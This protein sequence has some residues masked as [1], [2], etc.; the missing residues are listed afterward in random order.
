M[1]IETHDKGAAIRTQHC[2]LFIVTALLA[3]CGGGGG[4]GPSGPSTPQET[5]SSV[6]VTP[7]AASL[8][9]GETLQLT[10]TAVASNGSQ[11]TGCSFTF[12]SLLPVVAS[13]T[14]S[15]L[16]SAGSPGGAIIRVAANC[17]PAGTGT[18]TATITVTLALVTVGGIYDI[19]HTITGTN[20]LAVN[21]LFSTPATVSHTP[22]SSQIT[23]TFGSFQLRGT[24]QAGGVFVIS[25]NL[26][27]NIAPPGVLSQTWSVQGQFTEGGLGGLLGLVTI[28]TSVNP[29]G[30]FDLIAPG[31]PIPCTIQATW[32]G[33]KIAGEPND[34]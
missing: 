31:D 26:V 28:S 19:V 34:L 1:R 27:N 18:G 25:P 3:S 8:R 20:C 7:N 24:L 16:V 6:L 14:P 9:S 4:G 22:G 2:L 29:D 17:G 21:N 15:G 32:E 30:S 12:T 33:V 11:I 5:V 10:A 13:V 23:L